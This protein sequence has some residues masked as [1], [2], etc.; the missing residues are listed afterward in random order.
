MSS[1]RAS[2]ADTSAR[3]TH[4]LRRARQSAT[5][6]LRGEIVL[7]LEM[8]VKAAM[9]QGGRLHEIGDADPVEAVLAEQL[10]G[11]LDDALPI[12]GCLFPAGLHCGAP[13]LLD[14]KYDDHHIK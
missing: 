11:D 8:P 1:A 9:R 13:R 6:G 4:L 10:P 2:P 7:G 12:G 5:A 3:R 14:S